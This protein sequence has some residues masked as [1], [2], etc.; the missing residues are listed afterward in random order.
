MESIT[1]LTLNLQ[2]PNYASTMYAVQHDRLSRKVAAQLC[3]GAIPFEPG[4]GPLAVVRYKKPDGT[5]GFYDADEDDNP[6]VT[7]TGSVATIMLAEQ[8]LTVPGDVY[9]QLNF[10]TADEQRLTSFTWKI[11]VEESVIDDDTVT[12]TDYFNILTQQIASIL[13]VVVN[14]PAPATDVP[15]MD[16]TAAIGVKGE[17][18]RSDH[19]HPS[20]TTKVNVTDM[21]TQT[22]TATN[23]MSGYTV[24]I[25]KTG[26]VVDIL[27]TRSSN[28]T[29]TSGWNTICTIPSGARPSTSIDFAGV[30]YNASG[31]SSLPMY[32]RLND[33][34]NL[35]VYAYS[36]GSGTRPLGHISF[37]I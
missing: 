34:G 5:S 11:V 12:S 24:V 4:Y 28:A 26:N 17:F 6:A 10:Y 21:A 8:M 29:L 1:Q 15:L 3:D 33:S 18:A 7:W 22:L 27:A 13:E 31:A 25:K 9:C 32:F 2:A 35:N 37:V 14:M 19:V 36:A 20:D 23:I 30:D 16:G